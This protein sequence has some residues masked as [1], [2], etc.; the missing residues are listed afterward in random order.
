MY[1]A[2]G[3]SKG[4]YT[5]QKACRLWLPHAVPHTYIKKD[6]TLIYRVCQGATGTRLRVAMVG[7]A[8]EHRLIKVALDGPPSAVH[9]GTWHTKAR[10]DYCEYI[11]I[12]TEAGTH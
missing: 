3:S 7:Q 2:K 12:T 9:T 5:W 11:M 10:H 6:Y 1:N 8:V 4:T